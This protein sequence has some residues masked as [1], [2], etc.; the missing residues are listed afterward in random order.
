M[1]T[2]IPVDMLFTIMQNIMET[3]LIDL[4]YIK[5]TLAIVQVVLNENYFWHEN[6]LY[7]QPDG[8][9]MGAPTSSL[10]SEVFLQSLE[11]NS[12]YKILIELN[13]EAY[14]RYVDDIL[15]VYDNQVTDIAHMLSLFNNL[16]PNITFTMELEND[17]EINF[18]D[19]TIHRL[20]DRVHASIYR[21][22]TASDSLIHFEPCHT[23]EHKL[24]GI[25]HLINR[26]VTYPIPASKKKKRVVLANKLLMLMDINI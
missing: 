21:K 12:I 13:I 25:N 11:H 24:A 8:L 9:A 7:K 20:I 22:P 16:H 14:I 6:E 1:Y 2:N 3:H 4:D 5:H 15:I 23:V 18:L 17:L 26:I 19:L 10:L